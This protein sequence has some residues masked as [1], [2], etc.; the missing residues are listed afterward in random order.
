MKNNTKLFN[1]NIRITSK[2]SKT[3][4]VNFICPIIHSLLV[5]RGS[6]ETMT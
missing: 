4:G 1:N 5:A 2:L 3:P 6:Y